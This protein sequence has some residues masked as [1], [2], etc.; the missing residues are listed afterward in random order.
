MQLLEV[1]MPTNFY[2]G[3][4]IQEIDNKYRS[5]E[6]PSTSVIGLVG[7]APSADATAFPLNKPVLLTGNK[8]DAIAAL[9]TENGADAGTLRRSIIAIESQTQAKIIVVR[10]D[11]QVEEGHSIV[12]NLL[13]SYDAINKQYTGAQAFLN[14]AITLHETPKILI[15]PN[16]FVGATHDVAGNPDE[17]PP[18]ESVTATAD[19]LLVGLTTIADK[20]KAIVVADGPNL[21]DDE[22]LYAAQFEGSRSSRVYMVDPHIVMYDQ[23]S[24][25]TNK[26]VVFGA[27]PFVAGVIAKV[28][29]EEGF[30]C[31]PSNHK[32]DGILRT[33]RPIHFSL[34][35]GEQNTN[36]QLLNEH[37]VATI[38]HYDGFRLYGNRTTTSDPKWRFLSVRRT[39]DALHEA[40]VRAHFWALDRNLSRAYFDE[41]AERVNASIS[42]FMAIGALLG[43]KC[44]PTSGMNN[45]ENLANGHVYFDLEFTPP[46]PVERVTFRSMLVN[47]ALKEIA[48]NVA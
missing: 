39:A 20:L 26:E 12:E 8:A 30:W 35:A 23:A 16:Y 5:L 17:Q 43:G 45:A 6:A 33:D 7:T 42:N 11:E 24:A 13:G 48:N 19:P 15:A 27:S 1:K 40:L 2:H 32:I 46:Y 47:D 44:K 9:H 36:A 31:S 34:D 38:I 22:A 28:D 21:T 18:I 4:E 10:V 25:T 29:S 37:G 14:T 3:V 41:V